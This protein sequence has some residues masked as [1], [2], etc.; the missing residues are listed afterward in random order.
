[1]SV[2][3]FPFFLLQIIV[4]SMLSRTRRPNMRS[5]STQKM[6][7]SPLS[8]TQRRSILIGWLRC[9]NSKLRTTTRRNHDHTLVRNC[10]LGSVWLDA[11]CF[12][13]CAV[14]AVT[15]FFDDISFYYAVFPARTPFLKLRRITWT[16]FY[17]G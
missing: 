10:M 16:Q 13:L 11:V 8:A 9:R 6:I 12:V 3:F 1:M 14:F 17:C 7:V 5:C 4:A 15:P 2:S